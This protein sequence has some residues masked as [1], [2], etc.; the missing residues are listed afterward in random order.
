MPMSSQPRTPLDVGIE[1][2]F[3]VESW[4]NPFIFYE[5]EVIFYM[6]KLWREREITLDESE[7]L[8]TSLP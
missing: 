7:D 1:S 8:L 5:L 4:W 6:F 3:Q 2:S